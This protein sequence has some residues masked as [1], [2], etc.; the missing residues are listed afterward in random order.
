MNLMNSSILFF[1]NKKQHIL[2]VYVLFMKR[3][4]TCDTYLFQIRISE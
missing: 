4:R 1:G 2:G 3:V